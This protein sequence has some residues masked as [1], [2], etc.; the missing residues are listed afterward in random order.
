MNP[1]ADQRQPQQPQGPSQGANPLARLAGP[2][3]GLPPPPPAPTAAQTTAAVRRFGLVQEAMRAVMSQDGYGRQNVRPAILD[4]ASKLLSSRVLSLP[5][6][7][8][9]IGKVPDD[10]L[11][12]KALVES[13]FNGARQAEASVID[14]YGSAIAAGRVPRGGGEKYD[15]ANHDRHMSELLKHYPRG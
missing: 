3:P 1:L 6:V 4:Q 11:A 7:M 15:V 9:E 12:Q 5:E 10:P 14:H 13:I 8:N 2:L